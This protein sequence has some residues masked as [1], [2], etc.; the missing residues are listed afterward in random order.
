M[1]FLHI[2]KA[3][4]DYSPQG[5]SEL[6]IKEGDILYILDDSG[7]DGWWKAKKKA[8][9]DDDDEPVGLIPQ[10]YVEEAH[11]ISHAR[12]LFDYNRQTDEELSFTEDAQ[13]E[14]FDTSDPDWILVGL[15]NEYGFAPANYIELA[16][17]QPPLPTRRPISTVEE[18]P[19]EH[20]RQPEPASPVV[21]SPA[22]V[23]ASVLRTKPAPAASVP[24]L[25]LPPRPQFT[26]DAS[27]EEE[28]SPALPVRPASIP[29]QP[30]QQRRESKLTSP[31]SPTGVVASPGF[32]RGSYNGSAA[33]SNL[34]P[35][36]YHLYNINE[37]I[38]VMGKRKKMPT[39]L[40]I[41]L[42]TGTIMIAPEKERDGPQQEWTA[43][44]MKSY[45]LEG[46][47]VFI[48][49][50]RPSKSIEF[51]AGAK[52][53]A[54]E[55]IQALG[56]LS[57]AVR[58]EGLREVLQAGSGQ[59][60]KTGKVLYDFM[61]QGDDEVTVAVDD[62]VVILDDT[63]SEEWWQV[64]RLKNGKQGV[65]PS[66][67]I[68][69]MEVVTA[70]S[71]IAGINAGRSRTEQN[72]REEERLAREA[73]K[74]SEVGP[75]MKL[76][77]RN[78]SRRPEGSSARSS[79]SKPD[80]AKV[81]TWTDRSK[82]FSVDA[83]FLTLKDGKI[84]LHKVNGVKIAVPVSKMSI[85]DLDYVERMTG[86]SLDE[87]K[88]LSE[89][90]KQHTRAGPSSP[91][92]AAGAIIEQPK[93]PEYD[94]FQFFLSCDIAVGL[95]NRYS[96]IFNRGSMD[97][98]VLP[99]V[100]A[101]VLRN[102][103]IREGD[104][105]KIIRHL[106]ASF[107]RKKKGVSFANGEGED[108]EGSGG[109]F[110]G[111][112]GA[113]RNNTR[114]GR[115]AP[116]VQTN[117]VVDPAAFSQEKGGESKK[118]S[119]AVSTPLASAPTPMKK[120]VVR[121][122]FD[123]DA[124]NVKPAKEQPPAT[125][126]APAPVLAPTPVQPSQAQQQIA[127]P[128]SAPPVQTL[129]GSMQDLSLLT[130][131][132]EPMRMQ[133]Q[134][135]PAQFQPAPQQQQAPQPTGANPSFFGQQQTGFQP[136][137]QQFGMQQPTF[138]PQQMP[139]NIAR[140]RPVAPQVTQGPNSL[141]PPPPRPLSA[142][143]APQQNAF[144][145][146]PPLQAQMTGMPNSAGFQSSLA[147]PGTSLGEINQMRMQQQYQQQQ[148]Q[149][150][151]QMQQQMQPQQT[152]FSMMPQSTGFGQFNNAGMQQQQMPNG[153]GQ[154]LQQQQNGFGQQP[155]FVNGNQPQ[156]SPFAD[157][158]GRQSQFSPLPVHPTGFQSSFPQQQFAQ[159][160]G[161]NS[162][163]PPPLQPQPTG[164]LISAFGSTSGFGQ[165]PPVPPMRQSQQG[166][167]A[168]P[169]PLVPQPTGPPPPVRFGLNND[170]KKLAP[171]PT[172][173]RANLAAATPQNPFGF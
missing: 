46:K 71:S 119:D 123:D 121:G 172:G 38:S 116:A 131:P 97:E 5:E 154:Q 134:P 170:A 161:I 87:D 91:I 156:N 159:P 100:D 80:S 112:G 145:P 149:Q 111:P 19:S 3:V 173:K 96:D 117:D 166:L 150:H 59:N 10:N 109:L 24:P 124:W 98:S 70:P 164:A 105:I 135:T 41:N 18:D 60:Q 155:Q 29:A 151:Q 14:V 58:A 160:T 128:P 163:L 66:S 137:A 108:A 142:P 127:R 32:N 72:R 136:Q 169:A 40:G 125:T 44:K 171:Q 76:P 101:V 57:G 168:A 37:M 148:Q 95:C 43:E 55:I 133:P 138:N 30:R 47:H 11:P 118:A 48:E 63:K 120:G 83:Q 49:L 115:P 130:K 67:Y 33:G 162:F 102:L 79:K 99:D 73:L 75:G 20:E 144:G 50:V 56:D 114:K 23:M 152:G 90:K 51:H 7:G 53:T 74:S 6:E 113:L 140:Q 110:S 82:S 93:K 158:T 77:E 9:A 1:G 78:S 8:S 94:W 147:A 165:P 13:L 62:E 25:A 106:D 84:H 107:N 22:A 61:A 85:E 126:I 146:P 21:Q 139:Q 15:D 4:Y 132:L 64:R 69:I 89:M 129:S 86:V 28:A 26:P 34:A 68:E 36:G 42:A 65:V 45:N 103:G 88:P 81:R 31:T 12:A 54:Q 143:Q 52:D 92:G 104:I 17:E 167:M 35:S 16:E 122:G 2:V 39:T 157:P 27:D 141:V 153:F